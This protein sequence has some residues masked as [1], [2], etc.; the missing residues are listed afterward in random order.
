[1][2]RRTK[3]VCLFATAFLI[4]L[5]AR[6]EHTRQWRQTDF[7]EFEKGTAKGV[8]IRSDGKL[9]PAPKFDAF[10]DPNLA[11]IWELRMDSHERL[12]AA[13]G[14]DAKVLRFDGTGKATT[15]FES[16]E[17][18]AQAIAFDSKD[19]L[20]VG[21]SPDG[22]VYKVTPD[23]Q[24]SVFFDP[25]TKYIWAL[26]VD[27][28]GS[29]FVA[30]GDT[31]EVFVVTPDGKGQ[32]LYQSDERHARS[33]AFDPKDN[34][35]IGTEPSGL[36]LRVEVQR[37]APGMAPEA[38]PAFVIY[39][40]NKSEV[41]SLV[42]DS[43]GNLYAA[44]VGEKVPIQTAPRVIPGV[45]PQNVPPAASPQ[46][47]IVVQGQAVNNQQPAPFPFPAV[48]GG[49]EVVKI[50][51]DGYPETLWASQDELVYAM[52]LTSAGKLLLGTG[53]KGNI[54]EL[55]GGQ[56]YATIART[57]SAE[58][59]SLLPGPAGKIFGATANAGKVFTLGPG[60]E[61]NGSF[62]SNV[63]DAKIFSHW[64]RIS[65]W[66]E[67]G[68]MQGKV[69]FYARS[70][71]TSNPGNNWGPWAGP[72]KTPETSEVSCP[73][74]RFIQW[75][76]VFPDMDSGLP[77]SVSWVGIAYQPKNVA[78]V[79]DDVALQVP[80]VRVAGYS[81]QPSGPGGSLPVQLRAPHGPGPNPSSVPASADLSL[82][83]PKVEVPPQGFQERGYQGVLWSAHDDNDDDLLFS[84][85]Y[86]GEG[87]TNWHL[88]RDKLTQKFYS[89]DTTSMPDGAYYLKIVAT[90]SP[91]NPADQSLSTERQSDRF[92]IANTPP[93]IEELRADLTATAVK[94]SF[95]GI[96]S[97]G[98]IARAQYSLDA[99]DWQ[100]VLPVG[101]LSDA[102]KENYRFEIP[103][104]SPGEH[105]VAVQVTD[106]FDNTTAAKV[107][108]TIPTSASK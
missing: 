108:F 28:Q 65:W 47:L 77:P 11:Y 93:R 66:G 90:D 80:G 58:V 86:R 37:K 79:I 49:A 10:P 5:F 52:S 12:F 88:L 83:I 8:A 32:L 36:I 95:G 9:L 105:V 59:T 61:S 22:K 34:L 39:E 14:P 19:N 50:A 27:S 53:D 62:E 25:K 98:E 63:F 24:K 54:V 73:P 46:G 1:M 18:A 33:L 84:V 30:T 106:A 56:V 20:Y 26:R 75:K 35:L 41:T 17:L 89:W 92:E 44:S 70:G 68:V 67:N 72:Y 100:I 2:M 64:G 102:P 13:G 6:A 71:N 4:P 78:P 55:E 107:T 81:T 85:Y 69:A 16:S 74:A 7:S 48:N 87:E 104:L 97:A 101:Q 51:P 103:G 60:Y 29:L 40:T 21:T 57:D 96:S 15:V 91:S 3:L 45:L 99:G 38:G 42:T 23:G 76:A 94:V 82:K 31:G 43:H